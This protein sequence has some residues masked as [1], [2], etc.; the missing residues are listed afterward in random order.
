MIQPEFFLKVLMKYCLCRI[1]FENHPGISRGQKN[2][3]LSSNT[4]RT[5]FFAPGNIVT[6]DEACGIYPCFSNVTAA[7]FLAKTGCRY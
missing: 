6:E 2:P 7:E 1:P 5:E 4:V 3:E